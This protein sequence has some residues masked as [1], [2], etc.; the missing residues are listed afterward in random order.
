VGLL[1]PVFSVAQEIEQ[2]R[3]WYYQSSTAFTM[4]DDKGW[5]LGIRCIDGDYGVAILAH[6]ATAKGSLLRLEIIGERW[7]RTMTWRIDQGE[8]ITENWTPLEEGLG[9]PNDKAAEF[10]EAVMLA[11]NRLVLHFGHSDAIYTVVL[12][13]DGAAEAIAALNGCN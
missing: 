10:A 5:L 3:S 8:P 13:V 12:A 7:K 2:V 1:L 9:I 11:K 4:D 6:P